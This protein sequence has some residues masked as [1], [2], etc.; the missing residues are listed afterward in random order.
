VGGVYDADMSSGA[1][2]YKPSFSKTGSGF[3]KLMRGG[4]IHRHRNGESII[5]SYA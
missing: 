1:M 2:I 3:K 5:I 4:R